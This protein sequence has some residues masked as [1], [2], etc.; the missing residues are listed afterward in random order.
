VSLVAG[1]RYDVSLEFFDATGA[2]I[3]RLQWSYPGQT[4]QPIPTSQLYPLIP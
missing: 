4:L 2:A 1:Q 3:I